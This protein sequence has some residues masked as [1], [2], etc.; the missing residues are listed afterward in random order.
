MTFRPMIDNG[1]LSPSGH[2]SKRAHTA[3]LKRIALEL[4]GPEGLQR[5]APEKE[6][7]LRNAAM[8]RDLAERGMSPR[9]FIKQA[10]EA[11]AKAAAIEP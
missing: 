6:I 2:V 5:V 4:F 7:L 3:S 10:K 9:K 8:W 1:L 11:E